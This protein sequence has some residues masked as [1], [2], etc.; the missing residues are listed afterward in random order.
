MPIRIMIRRCK[1]GLSE[2]EERELRRIE[3]SL[4]QEDPSFSE[5]LTSPSQRRSY[6]LK[7]SIWVLTILAGLGILVLSVSINIAFLGVL[8]FVFMLTG[9]VNVYNLVKDS[10]SP[11]FGEPVNFD[12]VS[13]EMFGK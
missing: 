7:L 6:R 5:I 12:K 10:R 2:E 8:A 4:Y 13:P 3:Q 9:A 1:M 11:L